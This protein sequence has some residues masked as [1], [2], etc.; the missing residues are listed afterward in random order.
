M[1]HNARVNLRRV[2]TVLCL[3]AIVLMSIDWRLLRLPFIS[4]T[5]AIRE[6]VTYT[7]R[8]WPEYPRFLE[9]VRERTEPGDS[10][11]I[12]LPIR[13]WENGYSY[14]Y[15][16]AS[17]FLAGREVLPV[18]QPGDRVVPQNIRDAK[19]I[20]AFGVRLRPPADVLWGS[21]RGTLLRLRPR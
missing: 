10:I 1:S 17:Y 8:A 11:A 19:Y 4:R 14:G 15:Y 7:D 18:V 5:A 21:G 3:A 20:A 9:G 2:L 13:S 6:M 12:I 16:R